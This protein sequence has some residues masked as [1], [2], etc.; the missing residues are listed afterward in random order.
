MDDFIR[1]MFDDSW[2]RSDVKPM[3]RAFVR[4]YLADLLEF[5]KVELLTALCQ[6][7]DRSDC[8]A[9]LLSA[10]EL[11]RPLRRGDWLSIASNVCPRPKPSYNDI[12]GR[13]A[14]VA[15]LITYLSLDAIA[16]TTG[17]D[18]TL[19]NCDKIYICDFCIGQA[20]L[21]VLE[22]DDFDDLNGEILC[23]HDELVA[24][25]NT[26]LAEDEH[27]TPCF[28]DAP[29]LRSYAQLT[30]IKLAANWSV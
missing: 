9:L 6:L 19:S 20:D 16:L 4:S 10:P 12:S 14:D 3:G 29:T 23:S 7:S 18:S 8:I 30:R 15:F 1:K 27:L 5:N 11:W 21:L 24:A 28:F 2:V 26:L 17:P 22:E 13:Y 25:R